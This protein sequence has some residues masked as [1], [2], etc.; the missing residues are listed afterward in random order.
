MYEMSKRTKKN[1]YVWLLLKDA[2]VRLKSL[3]FSSEVFGNC[4]A[5]ENAKTQL[6]REM[7]ATYDPYARCATYSFVITGDDDTNERRWACAI[8]SIV[9]KDDWSVIRKHLM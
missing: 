5:R 4:D 9:I 2:I 6:V 7:E 1:F 3:S 8:A